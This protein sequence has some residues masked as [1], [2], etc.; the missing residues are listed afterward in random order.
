MVRKGL[1]MVLVA[2]ALGVLPLLASACGESKAVARPSFSYV[3]QPRLLDIGDF[4]LLKGQPTRVMLHATTSHQ[5][6]IFI[7]AA[8]PLDS[9]TLLR[10]AAADGSQEVHVAVT[11]QGSP[12]TS[13][14]QTAYGLTAESIKP[15]TYRLDLRGRGRVSSLAVMDR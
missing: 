4:S 10:V 11:L 13:G 6:R 9:I 3:T 8:R 14:K 15:G 1:V 2:V 12:H 5:L 7:L